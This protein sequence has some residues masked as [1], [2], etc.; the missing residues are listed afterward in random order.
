MLLSDPCLVKIDVLGLPICSVPFGERHGNVLCS[1]DVRVV[2]L[3]L[4][5]TR[6]NSLGLLII[7]LVER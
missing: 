1:A 7:E 2:C 5:L 3:F 6:G 4:F